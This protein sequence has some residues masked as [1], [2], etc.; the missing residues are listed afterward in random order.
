MSLETN[1][2]LYIGGLSEYVTTEALTKKFKKFGVVGQVD[3][4][5]KKNITGNSFSLQF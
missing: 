3:I 5:K 4:H 2:R 1:K